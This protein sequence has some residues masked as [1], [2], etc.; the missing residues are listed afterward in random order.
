MTTNH[1]VTLIVD[2]TA[3]TIS[4]GNPN[5]WSDIEGPHWYGRSARSVASGSDGGGFTAIFH[6]TSISFAGY[7]FT[8]TRP[9]CDLISIDDGE[10]R[11]VDPVSG[12]REWYRS[13]SLSDGQHTIKCNNM[14]DQATVDY[15]LTTA[16]SSTP[17]TG[18][19]IV[20]DDSAP[21]EIKY[22]GRWG[23]Q[24]DTVIS[25]G[26]LDARATAMAMNNT[27]HVSRLFNDSFEFRFAG[28]SPLNTTPS[29]LLNPD[30]G[31]SIS[32]YGIMANTS[33]SITLDFD[34]D[35]TITRNNYSQINITSGVELNELNYLFYNNT[36]LNPGNHTLLVNVSGVSGDQSFQ[37]DYLTYNP[38]F[39]FISEKPIFGDNEDS[40]GTKTST[41]TPSQTGPPRQDLP[42]SSSHLPVGAIVG[43]IAGGV[44]ILL[45]AL[46]LFLWRKRHQKKTSNREKEGMLLF[47]YAISGEFTNTTEESVVTIEPFKAIPEIV[48][49]R[50]PSKKGTSFESDTHQPLPMPSSSS[51]IPNADRETQAQRRL[52]E[53][54]VLSTQVEQSRSPMQIRELYS[55]IE[56][57]TRENER[58]V[59]DYVLP[60]E[61]DTGSISGLNRSN[62][63]TRTLP[64]Y[65]GDVP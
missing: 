42:S 33:G 4:P 44:I 38:S 2:A 59:R 62:S 31:S 49:H 5:Q 13:P 19:T 29:T 25:V 45:A 3:T 24:T 41:S 6:G 39:S 11:P 7:V 28:M 10:A 30:L 47:T 17:L 54:S 1:P 18:S 9:L 51:S 34:V 27:I 26:T 48:T 65:D 12:Y 57:L 61:Y 63:C 21:D 60:P 32:V 40:A 56:I 50:I 53:I 58:L 37:L 15:L 14:S 8:Q 52:D 20:V 36:D 16:G 55:R 23:Q 22:R 43:G 46:V 64:P 35:G